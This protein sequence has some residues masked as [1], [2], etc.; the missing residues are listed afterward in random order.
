MEVI[1]NKSIVKQHFFIGGV[2][3][4]LGWPKVLVIV[5]DKIDLTICT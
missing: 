3:R 5:K 1:L 2:Y 4:V